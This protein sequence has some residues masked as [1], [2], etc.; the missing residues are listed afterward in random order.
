MVYFCNNFIRITLYC[1]VAP[2]NHHM[3]SDM[4]FHR[5]TQMQFRIIYQWLYIKISDIQLLHVVHSSNVEI[6]FLMSF[7]PSEKEQRISFSSHIMANDYQNFL[8]FTSY[9]FPSK[10]RHGIVCVCAVNDPWLHSAH[11]SIR[12]MYLRWMAEA[13]VRKRCSQKEEKKKSNKFT[14]NKQ[15]LSKLE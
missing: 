9:T 7:K 8:L 15:K 3:K 1:N 2:K 14:K 4:N 12:T 13:Q 11:H 10:A 6:T 5:T